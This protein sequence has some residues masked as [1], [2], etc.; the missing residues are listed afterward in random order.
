[1]LFG[2]WLQTQKKMSGAYICSNILDQTSS[3]H[4]KPIRIAINAELE[5]LNPLVKI[6]K[7][8]IGNSHN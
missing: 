5:Q 4:T 2:C 1:M 3:E 6:T 8:I 7:D